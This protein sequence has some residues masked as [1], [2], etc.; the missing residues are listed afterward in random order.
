MYLKIT[1]ME[2]AF[3][4]ISFM[5]LAMVRKYYNNLILS[6][7]FEIHSLIYTLYINLLST[8]IEVILLSAL[9]ESII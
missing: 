5:P 6:L 4:S 3:E 7:K 8:E 2:E 1:K 9:L